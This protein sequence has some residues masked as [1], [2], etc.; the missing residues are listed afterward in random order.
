MLHID[1]SAGLPRRLADSK[2]L[3]TLQSGRAAAQAWRH[4]ALS[5][6]LR[7]IRNAR[8]LLAA[9]AAEFAAAVR[10]PVA[11]TLVAEVLPL[12][13]AWRFLERNARRLLAPERLH[14]GLP[15]WLFGVSAQIH[16]EPWGAVLILGPGNYPAFLPGVQAVQALVAGNAVCLKPAA[17]GVAA[18]EALANLLARAGLPEGLFGV[19]PAADGPA[20]VAAGFDR[21]V[22]T[23]SAATG[24]A[25]LEAAA[26]NL[27]PTTLELSGCDAAYVLPQAD[28][29]LVVRCL[30]YGLRLNGGATCIA[31]RRVF[32]TYA[33][34]V[35]LE[36]RLLTSLPEMPDASIPAPT[37]DRL[38]RL[39]EDA[40]RQ[41]A[42]V[43]H[44]GPRR[45]A[46]LL[47]A[48]PGMRLLQAD[49]FAPWLALAPVADMRQALL[50]DSLCPYALGCSIF[51]PIG[52]ARE[53][54][55]RVHAGSV[56]INDLIVPTADPRLGF[57]GSKRS[58]FGRT[59]GAEGLLEMTQSKTVSIRRG[60]F[61]PHLR[62]PRPSDARRYAMMI[63][64]L[65][66]L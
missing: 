58:G 17:E 64:A 53:L 3:E 51:G 26:P 48:H 65:H 54:A 31:P 8:R 34:A 57:G 32:C 40:V 1:G 44:P 27:T 21:I 4:V 39:L 33:A 29:E 25:V 6:R 28:L 18:A 22:L 66:R 45:P 23:G 12:L 38:G 43:N 59:R 9:E 14:G 24:V 49:L 56:C 41:G 2:V 15:L 16:R 30:L 55:D 63:R 13:E 5:R 11:D 52:A 37:A 50:A 7:I 36:R 10:R 60:F 35:E 46:L 47:D 62:A 19:L 20:A 61:R 42:R